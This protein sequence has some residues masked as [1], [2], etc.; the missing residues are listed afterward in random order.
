MGSPGRQKNSYPQLV[1]FPNT[2]EGL[3]FLK[4]YFSDS[5][6]EGT[7]AAK[8]TSA[9]FTTN[10]RTLHDKGHFHENMKIYPINS[11]ISYTYDGQRARAGPREVRIYIPKQPITFL[12]RARSLLRQTEA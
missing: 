1:S 4:M 8:A 3:K 7:W 2:R 10:L 5:G 12:F 6:G 11:S 9:Y